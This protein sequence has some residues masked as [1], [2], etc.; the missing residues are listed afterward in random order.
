MKR[1]RWKSW[2]W[3]LFFLAAAG[4]VI[5]NQLGMVTGISIWTLILT[6]FLV[7]IIVESLMHLEYF[8]IFMP[9]AVLGILY[10]DQLGITA[11][12]PWPILLAAFLAMI[13]CYILFKRKPKWAQYRHEHKHSH[14]HEYAFSRSEHTQTPEGKTY[15]ADSFK[16]SAE[17]LTGNEIHCK[18]SFG[19]SSKYLYS[20]NLQKGEFTC[21]FGS[22][23][24]FFDQ[25]TLAPEGAVIDVS[26]SFGSIE[27]YIPRS[28]TLLDN[29][30]ASLGG[31]SYAGNSQSDPN[32]QVTLTGGVSLGG[33]EIIYV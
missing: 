30:S 3:G 11:I 23:K 12:T 9:L 14:D 24:V 8:G 22:L 1:D 25:V 18:V 28:W 4:L 19:E 5:A 17:N 10:D 26:C 20:D 15:T 31:V 7:A 16:E 21:S 33:I 29:I 6:V 32:K 2:F 13:G 27:L